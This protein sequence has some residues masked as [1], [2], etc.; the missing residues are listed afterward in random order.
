MTNNSTYTAQSNMI[1]LPAG[2]FHYLSWGAEQTELPACV[3]LHG[4]TSS[5]HS[6]IRVGPAL[7]ERYRVFA[8]DMRGHGDS[9][10]PAPGAYG[11]TDSA[12]D[13]ADF[14]QAL[15][16]Q[17]PLLLGHS[18]GGATALI[19]ATGIAGQPPVV[20]FSK[21]ILEDPAHNF[22]YGDP[23][24]RAASFISDIGL[25]DEELRSKLIAKNPDWSVEDIEGKIDANKKVSVEA[26]I[27]VF[28]DTEQ[29]GELLPLLGKLT[30]PTLLIRA[31]PARGSTLDAAAWEEAQR[32]LTTR[33]SAIEIPGASHNIHRSK[34]IKFMQIVNTFITVA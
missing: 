3:L 10:K 4:I 24:K 33:S 5:S 29:D 17:N 27:S 30:A 25:P 12:T 6:W 14:I 31:D 16:L 22:G 28:A 21:V 23:R 15:D 11:L 34:F 8:M 9:I 1:T 26:V 32:F 2:H 7:A 20:N 13:A 19:L 18:W